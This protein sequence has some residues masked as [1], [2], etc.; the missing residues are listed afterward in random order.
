MQI[1]ASITV[2]LFSPNT[3]VH[4]AVRRNRW[5]EEE[6]KKGNLITWHYG[7]DSREG[8]VHEMQPQSIVGG[9][10]VAY[11]V[12]EANNSG[13]E[14]RLN[15]GDGSALSVEFLLYF[16]FYVLT[17]NPTRRVNGV[18]SIRNPQ[19]NL[20]KHQYKPSLLKDIISTE[21]EKSKNKVTMLR[22]QMPSLPS[23]WLT[24]E[25]ELT[26][27]VMKASSSVE[28]VYT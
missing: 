4:L 10:Y 18:T 19:V 6:C 15:L 27:L 24:P 28:M 3:S 7:K 20:R 14:R 9:P 22:F 23:S 21:R 8:E 12:H 2:L 25:R 26:Q 16:L 1:E 17:W 11:G 13:Q 5:C